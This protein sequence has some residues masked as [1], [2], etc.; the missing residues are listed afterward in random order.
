MWISIDFF[1]VIQMNLIDMR[2]CPDGTYKWIGHYMDHWSK[3][4]V[5]FALCQKSAAEVA[6]NLQNQVFSYLGTPK[7]LHS[8]NGREFVNAIVASL[9]K[10]WPGEVTIVNGR[11]RNPNCQGLVEQGNGT[12]EK[13]LGVRLLESDTDTPPWSEWLPVIQCKLLNCLHVCFFDLLIY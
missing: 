7:I 12:V 6:L 5:L 4:H 9:C 13:M 11:P 1:G 2:H 8:D 10:E 3:F